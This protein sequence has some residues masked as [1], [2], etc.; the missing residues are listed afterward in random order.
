M[1]KWRREKNRQTGG[2]LDEVKR[3]FDVIIDA[4]DDS[5]SFQ[6]A[7]HCRSCRGC[8]LLDRKW[9]EFAFIFYF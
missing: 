7:A 4:G 8:D 2:V 5:H 1:Q 9:I 6:T 3:A